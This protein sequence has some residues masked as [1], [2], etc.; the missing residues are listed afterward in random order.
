MPE[1][2]RKP[3]VSRMVEPPASQNYPPDQEQLELLS[4]EE[5]LATPMGAGVAAV[6]VP[7][8]GARK[9]VLIR[10]WDGRERDAFEGSIAERKDRMA[11]FRARLCA[12]VICD[13]QRRLLFTA[14]DVSDLGKKSAAALDRIFSAATRANA[15]SSRDVEEM[16]KN[17]GGGPSV[18]SGSS[19]PAASECPSPDAS[20]K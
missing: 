11:N 8:W 13:D 12:A 5:I 20:G 1:E 14:E 16:E 15:L 4:R 19:S 2:T 6:P 3:G 17:L 9:G 10:I 7:E 18:D